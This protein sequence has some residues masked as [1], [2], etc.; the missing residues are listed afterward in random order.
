MRAFGGSDPSLLL[1]TISVSLMRR[2]IRLFVPCLV[3]TFL[4]GITLQLKFYDATA[5]MAINEKILKGD[6]EDQPQPQETLYLELRRWVLE[7]ARFVHDYQA[8]PVYDEHLWTINLEYQCSLRL[9][10]A[11]LVMGCIKSRLRTV[12]LAFLIVWAWFWGHWE[13]CEFWSGALIAEA[14]LKR[15]EKENQGTGEVKI[16]T[17]YRRLQHMHGW[18]QQAAPIWRSLNLLCGLYLMSYPPVALMTGSNTPGFG[19]LSWPFP[20]DSGWKDA[21]RMLHAIGALQCIWSISS[22]RRVQDMFMLRPL[23]Y[24]GKISFALYLVHGPIFHTFGYK[25]S[26][27]T[28]IRALGQTQADKILIRIDDMA[29]VESRHRQRD[30]YAVR[31][32]LCSGGVAN[33]HLGLLCSRSIHRSGRQAFDTVVEMGAREVDQVSTVRMMFVEG[34]AWQ[35]IEME[36]D[37]ATVLVKAASRTP[38]VQQRWESFA[39]YGTTAIP[40]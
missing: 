26:S 27:V 30:A 13:L 10:L 22:I 14:N 12:S 19:M 39:K 34:G 32:G 37:T 18:F 9:Y 6:W 8:P 33:L 20:R 7:M 36:K 40:S 3:A 4:V 31:M 16:R 15:Q 2:W 35:S 5:F 17:T 38:S 28:P 21:Y 11:L 25:V 29:F 1:H 23:R 24:L